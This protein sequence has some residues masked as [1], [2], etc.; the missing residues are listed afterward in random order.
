MVIEKDRVVTIDYELK[1]VDGEVLDS[2]RGAEPLVYIHGNENIIPGLERQLVGKKAGDQ[3]A[4]VVPASEAYGERDDELVFEVPKSEF[5]DEAELEIGMQF[6]A[7]GEGGSKIVT[8]LGIEGDKVKLDANHP[9]AGEELHFD[10]K[11]VDVREATAEELEHGHVHQDC[12]CDG[13]CEDGCGD[14][15]C[16]CGHDGGCGCH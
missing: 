15:E 4:C 14:E 5:G 16:G 3:V 6:H 13:E 11:I 2:S 1:D 10:V 7:H 8:V 12:D 9:L